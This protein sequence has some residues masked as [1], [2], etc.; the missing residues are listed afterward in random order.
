MRV[1]ITG[2]TGLIGRALT[3]ELVSRGH[4]VII[5]SR[6]PKLAAGLPAGVRVEGWDARSAKGWGPLADGAGA[7]V[8]LAGENIAGTGFLPQRWTDER[9]RR[10]LESRINA[11][12]AVVEAVEQAASKA[13]VVIQSSGV[14][15]YPA[16]ETA[17]MTEESP[18][19]SSFLAD[20]TRDWEASTQAVEVLGVRRAIIRRSPAASRA[21]TWASRSS[22]C[23]R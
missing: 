7:I 3:A 18:R 13:G 14:D 5:L 22:R 10:I 15:Y 16:D 19:G 11:G 1:I 20:V 17:D 21:I 2:G 12:R 6:S 8:N 4:E 9:K 23:A